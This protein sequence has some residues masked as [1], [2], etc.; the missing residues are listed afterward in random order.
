[1]GGALVE[2][3]GLLD[4]VPSMVEMSDWDVQCILVM[5]WWN[6]RPRFPPD[7]CLLVVVGTGRFLVC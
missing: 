5:K 6:G 3:V 2:D 4:Y 1:M 7:L